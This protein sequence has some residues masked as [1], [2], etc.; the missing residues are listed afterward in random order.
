MNVSLYNALVNAYNFFINDEKNH[1][2]IK[3]CEAKLHLCKLERAINTPTPAFSYDPINWSTAIIWF[4]ICFP[5]GLIYIFSNKIKNNISQRRYERNKKK[6]V[7]SP[8]EIEIINK[9]A[10]EIAEA[11]KE[12]HQAKQ[13]Q[14]MYYRNN[15]EKCLSFLPECLRYKESIASLMHYVKT[16][17]A[18][19]L[20]AAWN[21]HARDLRDLEEQ[22]L[23]DEEREEQRRRHQETQEALDIIAQN[24]EKTNRELE[25]ANGYRTGRYR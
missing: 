11:K 2:T 20:D 4:L 23:R 8:D 19:T 5:F 6:L 12:L 3:K 17:Q 9:K 1:E 18:N 24:Q 15:Y 16:G 25:I 22:R 7:L 21:L 10:D 14:E 13:A